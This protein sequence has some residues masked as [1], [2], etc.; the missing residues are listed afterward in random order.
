[1]LARPV[2]RLGTLW[3]KC[4][5]RPLLSGLAASLVLAVVA[6]MAG[7]TW[8]WRRAEFQRRR[9]VEALQHG[10][11]A[12]AALLPLFDSGADAADRS[13]REREVLSTALL[14]YYRN[15][16]Q[17]QLGTDP[18]LRGPLSSM[19]MSVMGLLHADCPDR[20]G[21]TP[22]QEARSSFEGLLRDDPTNLVVR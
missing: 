16:I 15:S 14:E 5:R 20:R 19:T 22:W 17:H 2:G 18:E 8:Q 21:P 9:A 10:S 4:R 12:L 6:G 13:R 3:R 7:V 1:M 11:N